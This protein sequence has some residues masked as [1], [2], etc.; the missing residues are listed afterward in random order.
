MGEANI[1]SALTAAERRAIEHHK[2]FLSEQRGYDVGF[3]AAA[4]DWRAI[5]EV[6]WRHERHSHCM[7]LQRQEIER[8]KW[9]RS[10][11]EQRDL[12]HQAVF[13]WIE[14]YAATWRQWYEEEYEALP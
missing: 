9:I 4:A 8:H 7:A 10:E 11:E 13:E 14:K 5:H 12:G 1:D 6:A 3:D 2:Y